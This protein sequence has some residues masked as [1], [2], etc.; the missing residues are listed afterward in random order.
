MHPAAPFLVAGVQELLAVSG[1]APEVHLDAEI[2]TVGEPL[3]GGVIAPGVAS[4][5][6]AV[7][8]QHRR[9]RLAL[10]QG[11]REVAVDLQAVAGREREGLHPRQ[12][13]VG[14]L[15]LMVEEEPALPRLTIEQVVCNRPV[16]GVVG[17]DPVSVGVVAR[18]EH[19]IAGMHRHHRRDVSPSD[20]SSTTWS[21]RARSKLTICTSR[22]RGA[23]RPRGRRR[24]GSDAIGVAAPGSSSKSTSAAAFPSIEDPVDPVA[25]GVEPDHTGRE[26]VI[27]GNRDQQPSSTMISADPSSR[28]CVPPRG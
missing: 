26:R 20:G 9:Q 10:A 11:E 1:R 2:S 15:R 27:G 12:L 19:E 22:V 25:V 14:K 24:S 7:D 17:G 23:A 21:T 6:P 3:S 18:D 16:V 5:R 4:P 8:V 13:V 28:N